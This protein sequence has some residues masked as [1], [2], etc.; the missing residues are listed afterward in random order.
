MILRI[1]FTFCCLGLVAVSELQGQN[2]TPSILA[3]SIP[4][5]SAAQ[6]SANRHPLL[7]S[8]ITFNSLFDQL[9]NYEAAPTENLLPGSFDPINTGAF[10]FGAGASLPFTNTGRL[11]GKV[12]EEDDDVTYNRSSFTMKFSFGPF[13]FNAFNDADVT[14]TVEPEEGALQIKDT[15]SGFGLAYLLPPLS[16]GLSQQ[17]KKISVKQGETTV[18]KSVAIEGSVASKIYGPLHVGL[19]YKQIENTISRSVINSWNEYG[20]GFSLENSND[21]FD[22]FRYEFFYRQSDEASLAGEGEL[23]GN[24][25]QASTSILNTIEMQ[26]NNV[27]ISFSKDYTTSDALTA[28][29]VKYP[30]TYNNIDRFSLMIGAINNF[31]RTSI[32]IIQRLSGETGSPGRSIQEVALNQGF[33]F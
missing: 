11:I 27:V 29:G 22:L 18:N 5:T 6:V 13:Y 7:L 12:E 1:V 24:I 25:H 20:L 19:Q 3:N 16:F 30:E 2:V 14:K 26:I 17:T 15:Y 21:T 9:L 32:D 23:N 28:L 8:N 4:N 10:Y 33:V 31:S